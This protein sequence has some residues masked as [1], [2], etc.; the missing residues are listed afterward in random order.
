M[1]WRALGTGVRLVTTDDRAVEAAR[2]AVEGVLD[3]VDRACSR[4]REDSELCALNRSAGSWAP[5]G[6]LLLEAL[7]AALWAAAATGGA[8]DPTVGRA[9]RV[10]GYDRDFAAIP[11]DAGPIVVRLRRVPGWQ[12]V[13]LDRSRSR[14]RLAG[15]TEVDL[16]ST[17]K[18]LAADRAA[19]AAHAAVGPAGILVGLG[20]D[21][22]V[23]GTPPDGGRWPILVAEDHS[24][25]LDSDGEVVLIEDGG[26]ATS[27]TTVRRW[28]RAGVEMHHIIDPATGAP[29]NSPWRSATVVAATCLEAN[30]AA[31][32][33]I[34]MGAGAPAWLEERGL[35]A[36][37]VGVD[38][39]V[40]AVGGWP[41][42]AVE[43]SE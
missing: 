24:V 15:G 4:F 27:S 25:A 42:E 37:L 14:A 33:A 16:G 19:S 26:I 1:E 7:E 29:V 23:A 21:I 17:A 22:A 38:G 11:A 39:A 3:A 30:A 18:A 12:A 9:L 10:A 6:P 13:E 32:A 36:R 41:A 43:R 5:V 28:T 2:I 8:V 31:T 40:A 34:V 20:G 35:P